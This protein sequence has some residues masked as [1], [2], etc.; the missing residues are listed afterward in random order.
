MFSLK[1]QLSFIQT[2]IYIIDS[3]RCSLLTNHKVTYAH[4]N[5]KRT[6]FTPTVAA[7]Y[8]FQSKKEF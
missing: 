7:G 4:E 5:S 8:T 2:Y 3:N 1:S 6:G